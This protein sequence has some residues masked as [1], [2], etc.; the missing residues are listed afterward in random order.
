MTNTLNWNKIGRIF[1]ALGFLFGIVFIYFLGYVHGVVAT[2]ATIVYH[3]EVCE[4]LGLGTHID[5]YCYWDYE[6][7]QDDWVCYEMKNSYVRMYLPIQENLWL[8]RIQSLIV[9][10]KDIKLCEDL[11]L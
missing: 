2:G 10:G 5:N 7:K 1:L 8:Q 6:Y 3:K 9:F 11:P 4:V